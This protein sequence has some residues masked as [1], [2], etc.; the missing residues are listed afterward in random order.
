MTAGLAANN[1]TSTNWETIAGS[2]QATRADWET[3]RLNASN[4]AAQWQAL[5][6]QAVEAEAA[7]SQPVE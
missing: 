6:R 2:S 7:L 3:E 1:A 4:Q 5:Y